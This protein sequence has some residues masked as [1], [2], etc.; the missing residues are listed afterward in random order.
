MYAQKALVIVPVADLIGEPIEAFEL[1][2][3]TSRS[4]ETLPLSWGSS[5]IDRI[6]CP[7]IH[8]ALFGEVVEIIDEQ[9]DE[10]LVEISNAYYT[11]R[12]DTVA[13]N[14]YWTLKKY[15]KPFNRLSQKVKQ[16][17]P[18]PLSF[19]T[20]NSEQVN[21]GVVV[22]SEPYYAPTL[23]TTF[24]VGTRFVKVQR[25]NRAA[26]IRV[27]AY[28]VQEDALTILSIPKDMCV[29]P[30][31]LSAK[32]K[33]S[34]FVQLLRTWAQYDNGYIPYVWGGCSYIQRCEC[35]PIE[36]RKKSA[37]GYEYGFWDVYDAQTGPCAGFDSSGLVIRAAQLCGIDYFCKNTIT[38]F[39]TVR[40]TR[41]PDTLKEGDILWVPGG[42]LIVSDIKNNKV[43]TCFGYAAGY[44]K[45]QE[46]SLHELFYG[47]D[48]FD[49]LLRVVKRG[50]RLQL[51][52]ADG[53]L[54]RTISS[55]KI[56]P[57]EV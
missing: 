17:I 32:A 1:E 26:I 19:K 8:Q 47:I 7:R 14:R 55:L 12:Y 29:E 44:G 13:H 43:I 4:Y 57:L 25:R 41:L 34:L 11:T 15:L 38:A 2:I 39:R 52:K 16:S 51:L 31:K 24:S 40:S 37:S 18:E 6:V 5:T 10:V 23:D 50:Y 20:K 21:K 53:S 45:V 22:L 46:L 42:L 9:G 48:T 28:D 56:V 35:K 27:Y 33:K 3:D 54:S 36:H 49:E 30:A